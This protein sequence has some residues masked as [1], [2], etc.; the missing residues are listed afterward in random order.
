MRKLTEAYPDVPAF[1]EALSQ[2]A[3][4]QGDL[5]LASRALAE[6]YFTTGRNQEA[7]QQ[8]RNAIRQAEKANDLQREL[9][10][11]ER[12]KTVDALLRPPRG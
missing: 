11:K 3:S 9:A 5:I 1:W 4:K 12:L 10:L 8:L 6:Y 2:N 7:A